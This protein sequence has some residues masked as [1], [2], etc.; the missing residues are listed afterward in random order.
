M[1]IEEIF[2][3]IIS[4]M[5]EGT[6]YHDEMAKM[7]DFLGLWGYA[8]CQDYH[9]FEEEQGCRQLYFYYASHYFRLIQ[10]SEIP[11][12]QIIPDTWYKYTSQAVD[13]TT[14]QK[15]VKELI[16]KWIE[17]ERSTKRLYQEMRQE[18][19]A[20]NEIDAAIK[21]DQYICDVSEELSIAEKQ[22]LNLE[23]INYDMSIIIPEQEKLYR[24]Y[25]KKLGW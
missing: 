18:L 22:L 21:I 14:K 16:T 17:W 5:I 4:H 7:Y 25:K 19:A 15:T 13:I 6:I 11:K 2:N 8:R 23:A 24:K 10:I 20:L 1:T 12:P 9:H 3:K